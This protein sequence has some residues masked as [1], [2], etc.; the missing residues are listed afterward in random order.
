MPPAICS[1]SPTR[2]EHPTQSATAGCP[3]FA[4]GVGPLDAGKDQEG[5]RGI[6][7]PDGEAYCRFLGQRSTYGERFLRCALQGNT[8]PS[9][10]RA[11]LVALQICYRARGI[12]V[13][14]KHPVFL[15]RTLPGSNFG[16]GMEQK[17][18]ESVENRGDGNG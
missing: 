15:P 9:R 5:T 4:R 12:K 6:H 18:S 8:F 16:D 17:T 7:W 14:H 3:G 2:I 10:P 11:I 1:G 13:N